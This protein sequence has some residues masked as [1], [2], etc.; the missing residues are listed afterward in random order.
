MI[1][2]HISEE[3][4]AQFQRAEANETFFVEC[5]G[6]AKAVEV[7]DLEP[8][9]AALVTA[10]SEA[11]GAPPITNG[12]P[13][14]IRMV[15]WMA[16]GDGVINDNRVAFVSEELRPFA[17]QVS[18][19]NPVVMDFN[20]SAVK[21]Q[22]GMPKMIG[23]WTRAEWAHNPAA[24]NG[25]GAWGILMSGVMMAW[26][27]PD[28]ADTILAD[29]ARNGSTRNSMACMS[30]GI[31]FKSNADGPYQ[32][33][34]NPVFFTL[35]VLDVTP[36]DKAAIGKAV[37]G[38][39]DPECEA[40]MRKELTTYNAAEITPPNHDAPVDL[41]EAVMTE[42][43]IQAAIAAAAK[44]ATDAAQNV[45]E[46]LNEKLT[47][48]VIAADAAA[49]KLIE[50]ETARD[51]AMAELT[52]ATAEIE[53]LSAELAT[54]TEK[55]TV[56]ESADAVAKHAERVAARV[57]S[58][59]DA[60]R[61]AHATK[62]AEARTRVESKW[63]AMSDEEWESYKTDELS[64]GAAFKVGYV[65]RSKQEGHIPTGVAEANAM[66]ARVKAITK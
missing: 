11:S 24:A 37:E 48:G 40:K 16:H 52:K 32:V 54:T 50:V 19:T 10:Y 9:E 42:A 55:L 15:A 20:H 26:L 46:V 56:F 45:I 5:M 21:P 57:A 22:D 39:S 59:P 25:A 38:S 14:A 28:I 53:R 1:P 18:D 31:E 12:R 6:S 66:G 44:A 35:S 8:A 13:T 4:L 61:E 23:A 62:A 30:R 7:A 34:H 47:N 27:F 43:E 58:L 60:Y 41:Q 17:A 2:M 33:L 3:L 64:V 49:A 63:A 51:A 29:Q 65:F 36:A